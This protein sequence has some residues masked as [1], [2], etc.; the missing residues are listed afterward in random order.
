[1]RADLQNLAHQEMAEPKG[2]SAQAARKEFA[3]LCQEPVLEFAGGKKLRSFAAALGCAD[4]ERLSDEKIGRSSLLTLVHD[5]RIDT[6]TLCAA[7]LA[8]GG[9]QLRH[10]TLLFEQR[11]WLNIAEEIRSGQ[12]RRD[13]SYQKF[14]GVRREGGLKGMG[15]AYFTKLIHFLAP[16]QQSNPIGYI[17]DQWVGCSVNLL[18]S[19]TTVLMNCN[20]YWVLVSGS[21]KPQQRSTF[22][23]SDENTAENYEMFCSFI[24]DLADSLGMSCDDIDAHLFSAGGKKPK[25]WRRYV[26]EHRRHDH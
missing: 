12:L 15:P 8:W 18:T 2:E 22:N 5:A 6:P 9:M 21:E 10:A 17:M 3:L 25:D 24:D 20:Y 7:I 13:E 26:K 14:C 1:M 11:D 4:S 19:E 23:V 16:R